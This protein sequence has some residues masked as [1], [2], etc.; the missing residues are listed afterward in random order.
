M[1]SYSLRD[2]DDETH[3]LT[4]QFYD[5]TSILN[6]CLVSSVKFVKKLV[7]EVKGMHNATGVPLK[8]YHFGGDEAK[9]IFLGGGYVAY[10]YLPRQA[11]FSESPT[12][13]AKVESDTSI[14]S[15]TTGL[16]P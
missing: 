15:L 9:N 14:T 7:A 13:Q 11:P 5:H 6:P 2:P 10:P 1:L 3:L 8:S 16:S 12:C 4:I